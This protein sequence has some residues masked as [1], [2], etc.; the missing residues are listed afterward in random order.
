MSQNL[1]DAT[2][3]T[4][5]YGPLSVLHDVSVLVRPGEVVALMGGN[6]AGKT[7][8]LLTLAGE[9]ALTSGTVT[10]L[11]G[12][13]ARSLAA[14]ARRGLGF[15]T[16]ERSVFMG[17][18]CEENIRVGGC[19]VEKVLALFPEL[20][21]RLGVRGGLLSGGEQQM[22][23]LGRALARQPQLLFADELSMGLAPKIVERLLQA[24]RTAA[25]DEGTGVLLVEQHARLALRY[26]DRAYVMNR[27]EIALEGPSD[28]LLSR[29]DD[30]ES[31]YFTVGG[32]DEPPG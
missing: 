18:T 23:S 14:R 19:S 4:A 22:L 26:A 11:G 27:G 6:G 28:E 32:Q 30:I 12:P 10:M 3:V 20:E 21:S 25:D 29:A 8:L 7:T 2:D 1:L 24:I 15:V 16:E 31:Q 17:L 9:L 13:A 5:G